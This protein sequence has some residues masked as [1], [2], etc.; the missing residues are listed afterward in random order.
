MSLLTKFVGAAPIA[1]SDLPAIFA[2]LELIPTEVEFIA[3]QVNVNNA[4]QWFS[5]FQEKTK[6]NK[7]S[8]DTQLPTFKLDFSQLNFEPALLGEAHLNFPA[9]HPAI[10]GAI[11]PALPKMKHR[12]SG[13]KNA[14]GLNFLNPDDLTEL[15]LLRK[16]LE[17][18]FTFTVGSFKPVGN[19]CTNLALGLLKRDQENNLGTTWM[20]DAHQRLI[21]MVKL[22]ALIQRRDA[23]KGFPKGGSAFILQTAKGVL[24]PDE[25]MNAVAVK[26]IKGML[27][28]HS[29]TKEME[30]VFN[31][32]WLMIVD[33]GSASR[34]VLDHF[35]V[36]KHLL[37]LDLKIDPVK[38]VMT[39]TPSGAVQQL[40]K[41]M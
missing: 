38:R 10:H 30:A 1:K 8:V 7:I 34:K 2:Q 3:N 12:W 36:K 28:K 23:L 4:R 20:R 6:G 24:N 21:F 31:P 18:E 40:K 22:D 29:M 37:I 11:Q 26:E 32:E 13:S 17:N 35:D 39:F 33:I 5:L 27:R 41:E 19:T 9:D 16:Q 25:P 14:E 15:E